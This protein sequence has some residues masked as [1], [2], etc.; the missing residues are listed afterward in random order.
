MKINISPTKYFIK[1]VLIFFLF[2]VTYSQIQ[3]QVINSEG[4]PLP[5]SKVSYRMDGTEK[6]LLT[7]R[8]GKV[9]LPI[10]SEKCSRKIPVT[11]SY[12][13]YRALQVLLPCPS[14]TVLVLRW[15]EEFSEEVFITAE[16][17]PTPVSKSVYK[18][19][20]ISSETFMKSGAL[21]LSEVLTYQTGIRIRQDNVLGSALELG[22]MSGQNVKILIDGVPVIGR[23]GGNIDL[24]QLNLENV[25]R[26]EIINAPLSVN[27]GTNALAGTVNIITR[28]KFKEGFSGN[29][30][31]YYETVGNYNLTGNFVYRKNIH[32]FKT[33]L[34][35]KYF[36]GWDPK[37]SFLELPRKTLADTNRALLWDPKLQYF[38]EVQ[39]ILTPENWTINPYYRYYYE[40]ITNRSFPHPPY[41][42]TAFDDYYYTLRSD[43]GL[44]LTKYFSEGNWKTLANYNTYKRVKNTYFTD[45]TT[46]EQTLTATPGD[47]DTSFFDLLMLRSVFNKEF[48]KNFAGQIGIDLNRESSYA[49]R[50]AD[51]RQ[52][53]GDYAVFATWKINF[54]RDKFTVKPAVRF[55]YNTRY[56]APVIPSLNLKYS[57]KTRS[58][59][60][61][62]AKGFR[63]PT[64]KELF[65]NFIDV[66]HNIQGNPSL[67]AEQSVNFLA[68]IDRQKLLPS[69]KI[70][71]EISFFYNRFQD[72][73]TLAAVNSN[74]FS[75]VNLGEY[76]TLGIQA[77][78]FF[79]Y[80]SVTFSFSPA[81]IGRENFLYGQ[82]PN[83]ERYLFSPELGSSA[84]WEFK[85]NWNLN[86]F[87]KYNGVLLQ[88]SLEDDNLTASRIGDY[89]I[90][91]I[92]IGKV[93][94]NKKTH[95]VV[96]VKNLLNVK[97]IP[98][99]GTVQGGVHSSG[100]NSQAVARG[101]SLFFSLNYKFD[102][103]R[104]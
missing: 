18:V 86:V 70:K 84:T 8:D 54:F 39:Y 21:T 62:V 82:V 49:R 64:L 80:K 95:F 61:S 66:N 73:I 83:L 19:K 55:T 26:I 46:L 97:N 91:D 9:L 90:L 43:F 99:S 77:E 69:G 52:A 58:F 6:I 103:E 5:G 28:K 68:S 48:R 79:K 31:T 41:Y 92:S 60:F 81:Y 20:V 76:S 27:Y 87:Y 7:G 14:D 72:L 17:S 78:L 93:S 102:T 23:L 22:G 67:K 50:I 16:Y 94:R 45:L 1:T 4:T 51:L 74:Q 37:H 34:G 88:Y 56:K 11:I 3:I 30:L 71:Q 96:G 12:V 47:Q 44:S 25:E 59:K 15:S 13:G 100:A 40:K 33:S 42:E 53:I 35:R 57:L 65:L 10:P 2:S 32:T 101:T 85:K 29:I 75:Y 104:K 98:V 89:S 24:S 38:G 36:D 63:A